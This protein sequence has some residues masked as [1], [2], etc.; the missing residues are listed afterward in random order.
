MYMQFPLLAP[1]SS[2]QSREGSGGGGRLSVS[3]LCISSLQNYRIDTLRMK[4]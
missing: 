3:I 1:C 2:E 4:P